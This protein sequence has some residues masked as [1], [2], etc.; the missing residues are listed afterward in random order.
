MNRLHHLQ[1]TLPRNIADNENYNNIEFVVLDYNSTD[2]LGEWIESNMS[3]HISNGRLHYFHTMAPDTYHPCH[4]RNMAFLLS[5]GQL[6]CNVDADN[7]TGNG[8]AAYLNNQ[9]NEDPKTVCITFGGS[10]NT[11]PTDTYGR[12]AVNRNDFMAVKGY[13]EKIEVYCGEDVDFAKRVMRLHRRPVIIDNPHFLHRIIHE[14]EE[15]IAQMAML[16]KITSCYLTTDVAGFARVLFMFDNARF[17]LVNLSDDNRKFIEDW[18]DTIDE[19]NYIWNDG[20]LQLNFDE[21]FSWQLASTTENTL[22]FPSKPAASFYEVNKQNGIT[23]WAIQYMLRHFTRHDPTRIINKN[24][25]GQGTVFHNFD[26][27]K[28]L[29]VGVTNRAAQQL[30]K[31]NL[32]L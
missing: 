18:Q 13:D 7:F 25:F 2:G 26:Y 24:G 1:Q 11:A 32:S 19:G 10:K 3:D 28:A 12:V 8:F 29:P 20:L 22:C 17:V 27:R 23:P 31:S 6:I 15:R 14:D 9:F 30:A 5:K 21:G 16:K 4:S